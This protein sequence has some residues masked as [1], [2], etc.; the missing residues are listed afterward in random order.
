MNHRLNQSHGQEY[1][2][3]HGHGHGCHTDL[4]RLDAMDSHLDCN[5][6]L[7]L[8]YNLVLPD[9]NLVSD[10]VVQYLD[11]FHPMVD[12]Y[13]RSELQELMVLQGLMVPPVV[14]RMAF[15]YRCGLEQDLN[16]ILKLDK[17]HRKSQEKGNQTQAK[18]KNAHIPNECE[19]ITIEQRN[20]TVT[21]QKMQS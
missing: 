16:L 19:Q 14:E 7:A 4:D 2:A 13:G 20:K 10:R 9:Y 5:L 3:Y 18:P 17:F 1:H 6:V 8:D 11:K 15:S 12:H 21:I